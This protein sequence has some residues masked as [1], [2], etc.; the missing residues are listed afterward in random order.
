M[1]FCFPFFLPFLRIWVDLH[2]GHCINY[3]SY[4]YSN[5]ATPKGGMS[6]RERNQVIS[7]FRNKPDVNVFLATIKSV[8]FGVTLTEASYV[9]HF[10]HPWNPAQ[11]QNAEDR[12]HRIGQTKHLTVYSFWMKDTIEKRIKKKLAEKHL[13]VENVINPL[14]V[15]AVENPITTEE[16]LDILGIETKQK[17]NP[18]RVS[19]E[20]VTARK[21]QRIQQQLDSLQKQYDVLSEKIAVL[22]ENSAIASETAQKFELKKQI[23]KA[24]LERTQL[25]REIED[26]ENKLKAD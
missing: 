25:D 3:S 9:I 1:W 17:T 22:R 24:E 14:A 7:D 6:D 13:L 8:G 23:E 10:D 12:A 20:T 15:E 26:L 5:S 18:E 4:S 11:M 21:H 19:K 16:W 2:S